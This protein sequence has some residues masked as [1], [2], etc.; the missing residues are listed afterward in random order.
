MLQLNLRR[1]VYRKQMLFSQFTKCQGNKNWE[2]FRKQINFVT[3]LEKTYILERCSGETKSGDFWKFIKPFFS[4]K[5]FSGEHKIVLNESDK[6]INDQ[7]ELPITLI[8]FSLL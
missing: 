5:G 8:F 3:K 7:K 1:A 6:I 2:K 4:K